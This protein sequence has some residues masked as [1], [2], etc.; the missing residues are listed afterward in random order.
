MKYNI[1]YK[2]QYGSEV[3]DEADNREEAIFLRGEYK[4]AFN[5]NNITI[6][7]TRK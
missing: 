7:T 2:S 5:T 1:I 4:M 3:I 6:K